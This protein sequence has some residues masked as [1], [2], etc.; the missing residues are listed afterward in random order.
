MNNSHNLNFDPK[1]VI[2]RTTMITMTT[3]STGTSA[4]RTQE[5]GNMKREG[6]ERET[7][8]LFNGKARDN[9]GR[10]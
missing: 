6:E 10:E 8:S 7:R 9:K 2:R 5:W 3:R 4:S 1:K